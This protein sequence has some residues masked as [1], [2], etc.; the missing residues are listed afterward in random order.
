MDIYKASGRTNRMIEHAKKLHAEGRAVY[1]VFSD[2]GQRRYW[3]NELKDYRGLSCETTKTLGIKPHEL[4]EL[5]T[6]G[7]WPNCIFLFDHF[8]LEREI[9]SELLSLHL[10]IKESHRWNDQVSP[11]EGI[12]SEL[13]TGIPNSTL[14]VAD[15]IHKALI[16]NRSHDVPM[17]ARAIEDCYHERYIRT[18]IYDIQYALRVV[19]HMCEDIR[20]EAM[21]ELG[22]TE[23]DTGAWNAS[24]TS[25]ATYIEGMDSLIDELGKKLK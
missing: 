3:L 2:E 7:S 14:C 8:I 20:G 24:S 16:S 21:N 5:R 19:L 6:Q 11:P 18:K 13:E 9:Y 15:E 10:I 17:I 25:N 22:S 12:R 1:L 4:R 23:E